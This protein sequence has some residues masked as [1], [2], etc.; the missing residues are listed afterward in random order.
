MPCESAASASM[1]ASGMFGNERRHAV[2]RAQAERLQRLRGARDV[3]RQVG[4]A[5]A[6]LEAGLVPEH[7]R[8]AAVAAAQQVLGE[9]EARLGEPVR[10][11]HLVAVDQHGRALARGDH[12]AEVPARRTRTPPGCRPTSW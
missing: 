7:E 6:A 2:A 11:R 8:V 1:P 5:D 12:A 9:V 10:A 4:I 3:A